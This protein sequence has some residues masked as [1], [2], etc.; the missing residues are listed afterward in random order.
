VWRFYFKC[1][2]CSNECAFKTDPKNSDY[3]AEFGASRNHEPWRDRAKEEVT[4]APDFPPCL[5][6]DIIFMVVFVFVFVAN[7]F[8]QEEFNRK[9]AEEEKDI[10]R[11]LENRTEDSKRE[12][13]IMEAIEELREMSAKRAT[14]A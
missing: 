7:F 10:M 9:R 8:F 12:M 13:E 3:I 4:F 14:R 1:T 11:K 6:N 2:N 5:H